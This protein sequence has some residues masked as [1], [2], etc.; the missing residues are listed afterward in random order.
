MQAKSNISGFTLVELLIAVSLSSIVLAA[1]YYLL[2]FTYQSYRH[3]VAQYEAEQDARMAMISFEDD[4]RKAKEVEI[5]GIIHNAVEV[6]SWGMQL[7]VYTDIDKDDVMEFVQYKLEN[8]ELKRGEAE[9]GH[10]PT[11]WTTLADMIYNNTMTPKEA[12]FA[13]DEERIDINLIIG[14]DNNHLEEEPVSLNTSITV[15]SKGAMQ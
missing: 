10:T 13:V 7:D 8:N 6:K 3:T 12:I 2:S 14:D 9:L 5:S 4:I 11:K 1:L 15:R